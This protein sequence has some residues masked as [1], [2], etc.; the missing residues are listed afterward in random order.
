MQG[1]STH[2]EMIDILKKRGII[3]DAYDKRAQELKD[4]V[5]SKIVEMELCENK[6]E[7]RKLAE[8]VAK[9]RQELFAWNQRMNGPLSNTCEQMAEDGRIE[10]LTSSI[11]VKPDGS[12]LWKDFDSY[13]TEMNRELSFRARFEVMLFLQG[14]EADF[15]EKTPENMVLN[16]SDDEP[17]VNEENKVAILPAKKKKATPKKKPAKK[18]VKKSK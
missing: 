3:G 4:S 16:G 10:H 11:V 2:A 12:R 1:V 14:L 15:L 18:A 13:K 8:E 5:G 6:K 9:L 7:K 17:E